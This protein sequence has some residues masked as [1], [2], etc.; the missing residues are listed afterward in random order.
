MRKKIGVIAI[1]IMI[2]SSGIAI[3]LN[4]KSNTQSVVTEQSFTEINVVAP[5]DL[6]DTDVLTFDCEYPE[7]KPETIMLLCGDGGWLVY[8][9]KWDTWTKEGATGTGYF[10]ENLCEPNCAEGQRVEAP[11]NL[12]LTDLTGY[13]DKYY[14]RTLEIRTSDGKDFPWGRAGFFGWDVMEFAVDMDQYEN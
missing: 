2:L 12:V 8:K 1:C 10:S 13:K 3:I 14:L 11:V 5:K 9:I 4:L 6:K 7:Y